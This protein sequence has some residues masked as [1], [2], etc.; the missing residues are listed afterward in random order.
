MAEPIAPRDIVETTGWG[1]FTVTADQTTNVF[2]EQD[3]PP[4]IPAAVDAEPNEAIQL[5]G[6][7]P[8]LA[9]IEFVSRESIAGEIPPDTGVV[10]TTATVTHRSAAPLGTT[11]QVRTEVTGVAGAEITFEGTV[12]T[13]DN[14]RLVG[15]ATAGLKLVDRD[16]FR[17]M[18]S[19]EDDDPD[20]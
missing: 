16:R 8:L 14:G 10:G 3:D 5:L 7:A 12:R 13:S 18:V 2:G 6:T 20:G 11:V 15:S 4:G 17:E 19:T 1:S 9:R